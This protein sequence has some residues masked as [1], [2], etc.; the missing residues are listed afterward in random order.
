MGGSRVGSRHA[1]Q[2]SDVQFILRDD[3]FSKQECSTKDSNFERHSKVRVASRASSTKL[4][5]SSSDD[6]VELSSGRIEKRSTAGEKLASWW[7]SR[8]IICPNAPSPV[9]NMTV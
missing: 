2:S 1:S 6:E 4:S 8:Q 9:A 3:N 5:C 7:Q